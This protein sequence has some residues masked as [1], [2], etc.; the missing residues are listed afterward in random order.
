MRFR[1]Y[2]MARTGTRTA[3]DVAQRAAGAAGEAG[4]EPAHERTGEG[5]LHNCVM[6]L[7]PDVGTSGG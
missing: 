2:E 1:L 6:T 3:T 7:R 4:G 5:T